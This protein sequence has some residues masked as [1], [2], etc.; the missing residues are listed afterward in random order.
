VAA[1]SFLYYYGVRDFVPAFP[2]MSRISN[3]NKIQIKALT[4]A[5]IKPMAI[6][7]QL[8]LKYETVKNNVYRK[9]LV[10]GF[11]PK[12]IIKKSYFTGRIGLLIKSYIEE[13]PLARVEDIRLACNLTCQRTTLN[14]W[15]NTNNLNRTKAKT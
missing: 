5:G 2:K 12:V 8:L 13:N 9:K 10:A 15:L 6:A 11:P 3:E 1:M 14:R 7:T 4:D